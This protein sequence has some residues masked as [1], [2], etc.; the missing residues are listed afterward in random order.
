MSLRGILLL[1]WFIPS[2]PI[3]FFRPFYGI[4]VWTI[5]AFTSPQWYTW[6][7]A[8]LLPWALIIAVPTIAGFLVKCQDFSRLASKE[9]CLLLLLWVWFTFTT[10]VS[11]NSP[12]FMH[13]ADQTW[14]EFSQVSKIFLMVFVTLGIVDSFA[15]L[16][17]LVVTIASCFGLFVLKSVPFLIRT[18]GTERVYG[19]A[20]SM[21]ADNN[22]FGLALNMTLPIFLFLAHTETRPKLKR[23][24]GTLFVLTIPTIFFTYSR[25]ALL[26]LLVLGTL[27]LLRLRQRW[28]LIPVAVLGISVA[29]I[30]TPQSWKSR[31][32]PTEDNMLD[33]SARGRINAWTFAV[34]LTADYPI[35]GGGFETFTRTL[36][37]I[38]AP[39]PTDIH[40][41]HSVYFGILGEHGYPGLLLFLGLIGVAFYTT[42]QVVKW[43]RYY[44]DDV[45]VSYALMFRFS[46]IG[47][48]VAG[49]FLGRAY[50]DYTYTILAC[51]VILKKVCF[52]RWESELEEEDL[53]QEEQ[54]A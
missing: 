9:S 3:S 47:F 33:K 14:D 29:T 43:G 13:H 30:F 38:Y 25:G 1:L 49:L 8:H 24:W 2:V 18:S 35:T 6:G 50:F 28:I 37:L 21:I 11:V 19:P 17:T 26:S 22:D 27:M 7:A 16:R 48:L 46:L 44:D 4:V 31:M 12:V 5:V 54:L 51:I 40:G 52:Q 10:L 41:P 20:R 23:L 32:N 53:E 15:R 34:H 36:F 39:D 45:V 42:Y